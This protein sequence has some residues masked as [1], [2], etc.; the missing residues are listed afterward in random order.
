MSCDSWAWESDGD[1]TGTGVGVGGIDGDH[2]LEGERGY[3]FR[4]IKYL[5]RRDG[6]C[7]TSMHIVVYGCGH[8]HGLGC[9]VTCTFIYHS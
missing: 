5:R 3:G 4:L 1:G 2:G 6:G 9:S 8:G 7:Y